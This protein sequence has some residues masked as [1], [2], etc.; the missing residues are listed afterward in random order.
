MSSSALDG[1]ELR[2]LGR[3]ITR[4]QAVRLEAYRGRAAEEERSLVSW[5]RRDD[6]QCSKWRDIVR[7]PHDR[8]VKSTDASLYRSPWMLRAVWLTVD[9]QRL[10][11]AGCRQAHVA[12]LSSCDN[13]SS[14]HL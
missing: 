1:L 11:H 3:E 7:W 10:L 5:R 14:C 2:D 8:A 4:V 13:S 6:G 12:V 9:W